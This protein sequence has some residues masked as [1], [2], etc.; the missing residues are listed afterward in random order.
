MDEANFRGIGFRNN[1]NNSNSQ[2]LRLRGLLLNLCRGSHCGVCALG[3]SA[4][5]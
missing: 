2:R 3:G 4:T 5:L 1:R